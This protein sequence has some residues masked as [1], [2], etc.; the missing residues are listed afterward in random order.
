MFLKELK[1]HPWGWL[2]FWFL[3]LLYTVAIFADFISPYRYDN[4]D[5]RFA[6]CPPTPVHFFSF[7][8]KIYF[9]PFVY[10]IKVY[11]DKFYRRIYQ[12]DKSKIYFLKFFVRGDEYKFLGIFKCNL[13]LFGVEGAR[14][15]IWGSDY[16]GRDLFSR[17]L[18][19]SRI[20]LSIG[21]IGASISFL[22]GLIV[23]G[24]S[25]YVGGKVDNFIMRICEM[26]MMIP[27]FYLMLALRASF[28]PTLSSS[29][30]Y[31]LIV[32]ILSFIGWASIARV[33]RGLSLSLREREFVLAAKV[34]GINDFKIIIR[35]ILPHTFS[36]V[37]INICL[38]IP[39]YILGEAGLSIL[40][41]GIQEP[42]PS[43]GNL[44]SAAL[45]I[46]HIKLHPWILIPGIFIFMTVICFNI[47]GDTLRDILDPTKYIK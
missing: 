46:A 8:K 30:V 35:H 28:P 6:Y 32:I 38:S 36:F 16:R 23:G 47:L 14:I 15:Y 34:L 41:L 21:L 18:Y 1:K 10:G 31:L 45:G 44:L 13:H 4:E 33:I 5:R 17:I 11:R 42:Q 40:G 24:I 43:W 20:S 22:I 12:E 27:S 9:R 39:S 26:I 3:L 29:Q 7:E 2:S 19:G 25:G 37:I